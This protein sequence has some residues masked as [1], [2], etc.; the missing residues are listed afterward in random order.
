MNLEYPKGDPREPMTDE[1][2]AIKFNALS[3]AVLTPNRQAEIREA[4]GKIESFGSVADFMN[5]LKV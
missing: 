2:I 1:D 3:A 4:I 5:L